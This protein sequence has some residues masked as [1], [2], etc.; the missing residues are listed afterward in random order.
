MNRDEV[1]A[2]QA[3]SQGAQAKIVMYATRTCGYCWRAE[4]LLKSK[5]Y[6]FEIVDVTMDRSRRVWLAEQ[7]GRR[8][9]PQI[10]IGEHWIGGFEEMLALDAKGELDRLVENAP[11]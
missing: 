6:T 1:E 10:R 4:R 11:Q 2:T 8:T 7:S 9:V 5:G 3:V